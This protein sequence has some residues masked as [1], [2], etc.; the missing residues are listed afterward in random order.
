MIKGN[1]LYMHVVYVLIMGSYSDCLGIK[2]L[3]KW[4]LINHKYELKSNNYALLFSQTEN[5]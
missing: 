1:M 3:A 2:M 5:K 4:G